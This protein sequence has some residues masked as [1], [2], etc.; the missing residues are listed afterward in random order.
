[1]SHFIQDNSK[2][3]FKLV[4]GPIFVSVLKHS[5]RFISLS[6][7]NSLRPHDWREIKSVEYYP[8]LYYEFSCSRT[9]TPFSHKCYN[10]KSLCCFIFPWIE[11]LRCR[12]MWCLNC[13]TNALCTCTLI[14]LLHN[15]GYFTCATFTHLSLFDTKRTVEMCRTDYKWDP[16]F[17]SLSWDRL[18]WSKCL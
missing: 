4:I 5:S 15:M 17:D 12:P 1:M 18:F 16:G 9:A 8:V 6:S 3:S 14:V 10:V 11:V 2:V 13:A 7:C